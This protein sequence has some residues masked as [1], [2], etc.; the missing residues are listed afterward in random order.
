M[1]WATLHGPSR[2]QEA[3][4]ELASTGTAAMSC[5]VC[6]EV[7]SDDAH[8]TSDEATRRH[9]GDMVSEGDEARQRGEATSPLN[10][11]LASHHERAWRDYEDKRQGR[12]RR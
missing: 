3:S 1:V 6:G 5:E 9:V 11:D 4:S 8:T 2:S 7:S 10:N 12:G